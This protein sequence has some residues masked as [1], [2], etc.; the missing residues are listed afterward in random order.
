MHNSDYIPLY[1]SPERFSRNAECIAIVA[2]LELNKPPSNDSIY[3][4][5]YSLPKSTW[6]QLGDVV[7]LSVIMK[8]FSQKQTILTLLA[9]AGAASLI[10]S[11]M[12]AVLRCH[13]GTEAAL[14]PRCPADRQQ[15]PDPPDCWHWTLVPQLRQLYLHSSHIQDRKCSIAAPILSVSSLARS[16]GYITSASTKILLNVNLITFLVQFILTSGSGIWPIIWLLMNTESCYTVEK[17]NKLKLKLVRVEMNELKVIVSSRK[18]L[19][20]SVVKW[21][22]AFTFGWKVIFLEKVS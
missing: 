6:F 3:I 14:T 5:T 4:S 2:L 22:A 7:L 9:G 20:K 21:A 15:C 11:I 1:Q 16:G 10:L 17:K 8:C 18:Y 12:A 19:W 13:R